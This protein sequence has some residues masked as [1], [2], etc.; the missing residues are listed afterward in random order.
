MPS[1]ESEQLQ[2]LVS[3]LDA[4]EGLAEDLPPQDRE[5]EPQSF[6]S[7]VVSTS[8]AALF[9]LLGGYLFFL[10][11]IPL[12]WTLGSLASAAL[13]SGL[14]DGRWLMPRVVRDAVRPVLGV[15]AGSAFTPAIV[16]A[17]PQ[18]WTGIAFVFVLAVSC[19]FLGWIFF[20]KVCGYD[21]VTAFFASTP[22]GLSELTILGGMLGGD[23]RRLVL[24]H[25]VRI[26]FVVFTIPIVIQFILGHGFTRSLLPPNVGHGQGGTADAV[27]LIGCGVLGYVVGRQRFFPGGIMIASMLFSAG[28]HSM[29]L[30]VAAPPGWLVLFVQ[31]AIGC[32]A[33]SRFLGV[34]WRE[35]QTT[36]LTALAWAVIMVLLTIGAAFVASTMIDQPLAILLLAASPG[37]MAEMTII[38]YSLGID[39]AFVITCQV[40]RSFFIVAVAP[41][42][43]RATA[44]AT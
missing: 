1:S 31:V 12:P 15:L 33:G 20:Q 37:G 11:H 41:A 24:V 34:T 23:M 27:I 3:D 26:V 17:I 8:M 39:A 35:L 10:V 14:G 30:T 36:V 2:R 18:W 22:G 4:D 28:V 19:T 25:S 29:G 40:C 38:S 16:A 32:V 5:P 43:F 21:K 7:I 6:R 13:V 9:G 44:A 42:L